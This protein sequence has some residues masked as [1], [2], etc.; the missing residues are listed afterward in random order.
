MKARKNLE[1]KLNK[2]FGFS[3][4]MLD[5]ELNGEVPSGLDTFFVDELQS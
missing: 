1:G 5:K 3:G 2:I 4:S